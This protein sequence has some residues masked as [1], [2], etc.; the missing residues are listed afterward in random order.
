MFTRPAFAIFAHESEIHGERVS[1][2]G[3]HGF[4]EKSRP[5][6]LSTDGEFVGLTGTTDALLATSFRRSSGVWHR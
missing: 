2:I 3:E 4:D 5:A 1:A 6:H